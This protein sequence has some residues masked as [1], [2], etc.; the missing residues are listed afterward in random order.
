ML[1]HAVNHRANTLQVWVPA[2]AARVIRVT[3][4]IAKARPFAAKLTSH[5]HKY[6][7]P[8]QQNLYKAR[9]LAKFCHFRTQFVVFSVLGQAGSSHVCV[10]ANLMYF[11]VIG[12]DLTQDPVSETQLDAVKPLACHLRSLPYPI[13][14]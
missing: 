2:A 6:S 12:G 13:D 5:R 1:S 9:S 11:S 3:D 14:E 10:G 7:S 4:H 8:H